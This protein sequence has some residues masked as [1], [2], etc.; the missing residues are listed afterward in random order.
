YVNS[1]RSYRRVALHGVSSRGSFVTLS[2]KGSGFLRR[3]S[4]PSLIICCKKQRKRRGLFKKRPRVGQKG[5][6]AQR[7]QRMW[8][9]HSPNGGGGKRSR[10]GECYCLLTIIVAFD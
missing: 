10:A 2:A 7:V 8:A 6:L 9:G 5:A 1:I 3:T 4:A